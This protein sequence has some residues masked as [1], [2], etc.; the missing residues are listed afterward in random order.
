MRQRR[1]A[2]ITIFLQ[3][4]DMTLTIPLRR[5]AELWHQNNCYE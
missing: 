5:K 3:T 1:R 2:G 4:F